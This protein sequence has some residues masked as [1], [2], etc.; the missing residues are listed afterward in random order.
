VNDPPGR[1]NCCANFQ[2]KGKGSK[3]GLWLR[4]PRS[5]PSRA[6]RAALICVSLALSQTQVH[7]AR[8]RIRT[9]LVHRA[10]CLFTP[11]LSLALDTHCVYPR[12]DGQAE[13]AWV[14]GYIPR[15]FTHLP[16][17]THPSTNR[18]RH[19]LTSSMRPTTLRTERNRHL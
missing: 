19:R 11:Q 9:G 13:L 14:T 10:V 15:W 2:L 1:S 7:T 17:V 4:R 16:T 6:S 8:S 3:L 5:L 12:R 18:I